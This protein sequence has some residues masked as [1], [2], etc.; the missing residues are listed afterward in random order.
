M[1]S[2]RLLLIYRAPMIPSVKLCADDIFCRLREKKVIEYRC[3]DVSQFSRDDLSWAD[4]IILGRLDNEAEFWLAKKLKKKSKTVLYVMDDDLLSIPKTST[5]F[6]YYSDESIR[7]PLKKIITIADG[8]ISPSPLLLEKYAKEKPYNILVEEP[9]TD[10]KPPA[11][12]GERIRIAFAG[13]L[14]RTKDVEEIIGSTLLEIN[15]KHNGKVEFYFFGAIPDF[16]KTIA[17]QVIEYEHDYSKYREKLKNLNL[18]IGLAPMPTSLF[19]ACKHYNKYIEYSSLGIAGI[20]SNVQ[21]YTRLTDIDAPAILVENTQDDWE[22]AISQLIKNKDELFEYKNA[23]FEFAKKNFMV[24]E[25]ADKV[26]IKVR[27]IKQTQSREIYG[28]TVISFRLRLFFS[29]ISKAFNEY[30]IKAPYKVLEKKIMRNN[31]K[32]N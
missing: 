25:I 13:S 17:A 21:P 26:L 20:Y 5:S 15:K 2:P 23:C 12:P 6:G 9:A 8:L 27:G 24:S 10:F 31:V 28:T 1:E 22:K 19:H 29:K 11:Y 16:A 32:F 4:T 14:D 3:L 30:G 7:K 18:D